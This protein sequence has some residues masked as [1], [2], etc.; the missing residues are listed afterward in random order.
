[1]RD[2]VGKRGDGRI[3]GFSQHHRDVALLPQELQR[4]QHFA[5]TPRIETAKRGI[6]HQQLAAHAE[7]LTRVSPSAPVFAST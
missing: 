7:R 5:A 4:R 3:V 6:E 2:P 1:M